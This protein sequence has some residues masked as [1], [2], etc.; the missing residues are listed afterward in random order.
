MHTA[1]KERFLMRGSNILVATKPIPDGHEFV[2]RLGV[3]RETDA[4]R[5]QASL[6]EEQ[7][8]SLG[9]SGRVIVLVPAADIGLQSIDTSHGGRV[10]FDTESYTGQGLNCV[11]S[12]PKP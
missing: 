5:Y 7:I 10:T 8:Q 3:T 4:A 6:S 12:K 2:P 11:L 1:S 9:L